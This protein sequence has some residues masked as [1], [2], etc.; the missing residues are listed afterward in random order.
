[1]GSRV[2]RAAM[3]PPLRTGQSDMKL[4]VSDRTPCSPPFPLPD[5]GAHPDLSHP[6]ILS[7]SPASWLTHLTQPTL[8][9]EGPCKSPAL[10]RH[11][12]TKPIVPTW[13]C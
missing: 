7:G 1:M 5:P 2:S 11:L 4:Q 10:L 13:E 8:P 12:Q 3:P 9:P 6:R